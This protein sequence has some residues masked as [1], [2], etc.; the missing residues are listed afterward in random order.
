MLPC[1][2]TRSE[3][4]AH[5]QSRSNGAMARKLPESIGVRYGPLMV[6]KRILC[7]YH[8]VNEMYLVF[9]VGLQLFKA[10]GGA[11]DSR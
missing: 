1:S 8:F 10:V 7:T 5:G 4:G 2:C 3:E 11:I 6:G 9:M